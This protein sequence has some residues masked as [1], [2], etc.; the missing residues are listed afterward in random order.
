MNVRITVSLPEDL[1]TAANAAVGAGRAASVSAYVASAL[2][3]TS[4]REALGDVLAEWRVELG[5]PTD[6]E[7]AWVQD[8]LDTMRMG[9]D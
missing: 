3:D 8:A 1:V 7:E 2:R 5:P 9:R 6:E 4:E